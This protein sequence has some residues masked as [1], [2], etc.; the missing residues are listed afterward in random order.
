MDRFHRASRR[1]IGPGGVRCNCC[2]DYTGKGLRKLQRTILKR[3]GYDAK[4]HLASSDLVPF[5]DQVP[6]PLIEEAQEEMA[7]QWAN[8]C[9]EGLFDAKNN[10]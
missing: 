3:E 1:H 2:N 6:D 4:D 8:E 7:R 9:E 5:W 10:G